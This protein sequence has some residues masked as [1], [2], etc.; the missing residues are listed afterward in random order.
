MLT[1]IIVIAIIKLMIAIIMIAMMTVTIMIM[2]VMMVM[3][4]M[5]TNP[6]MS[7]LFN[8]EYCPEFMLSGF[9]ITVI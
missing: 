5:Y 6:N 7:F 2:T 9:N 4:L 1:M 3:K 8:A